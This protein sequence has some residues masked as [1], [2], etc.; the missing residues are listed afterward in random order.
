METMLLSG[1]T[2][3]AALTALQDKAYLAWEDFFLRIEEGSGGQITVKTAA[4]IATSLTAA[5]FAPL[6]AQIDPLHVG[7]A[8]REMQVAGYYGQRL[9]RQSGN[10]DV[11]SLSRLVA[12]YP[13]HGFVIDAQEARSIFKNVREPGALEIRL[14]KEL[15]SEATLPLTGLEPSIKFLSTEARSQGRGNLR[16]G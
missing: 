7:E 6:N 1:L 15:G 10:Y 9:M 16:E 4:E 8:A 5:L 11:D 14:A 12:Y 13:S 2:V 3:N